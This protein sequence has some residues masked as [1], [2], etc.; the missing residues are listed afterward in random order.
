M[1]SRLGE[2]SVLY[3]LNSPFGEFGALSRILG[4][5]GLSPAAPRMPR[6][7]TPAAPRVHT[8]CPACAH[9]VP[10][11]C[12][13]GCLAYAQRVH[14]G[15]PACAHRLPWF[16]PYVRTPAV[17]RVCTSAALDGRYGPLRRFEDDTTKGTY[18]APR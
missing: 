16:M 2:Q 6:V 12:T 8:G 13:I 1:C 17:P 18:L 4:L 9:R 14:I 10:R 15:C 11:V 7:C 3:W 5:K